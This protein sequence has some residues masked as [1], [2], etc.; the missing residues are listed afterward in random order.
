M[1]EN[2]AVPLVLHN[3]VSI[4][5][6]LD[7]YHF[8]VFRQYVPSTQ[9]VLEYGYDMAIAAEVTPTLSLGGSAALRYGTTGSGSQAWGSYFAVG[10]DYA[11]TPDIS[12]S[13]VWNDLGRNIS[14]F[15]QDS[16][17]VAATTPTSTMIEV[18]A[19]M[20]YPS[21]ASLRPRCSSYRLQAKK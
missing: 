14:Y 1:Q 21:S 15:L 9:R 11:P 4:A 5:L 2:V 18:G 8:G 16:S 20:T 13:L 10:A 17:V 19:T 3:P 12:Y 7:N 6:G